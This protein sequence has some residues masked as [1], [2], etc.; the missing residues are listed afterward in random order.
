M[1]VASQ[2]TA[3]VVKLNLGHSSYLLT[4]ANRR[5][6]IIQLYDLVLFQSTRLS[7]GC[8]KSSLKTNFGKENMS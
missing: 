5:R 6:Y 7:L 2:K 3:G 1:I 8:I 4:L